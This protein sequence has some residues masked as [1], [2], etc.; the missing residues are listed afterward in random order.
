MKSNLYDSKTFQNL[1]NAF[2][3]E[4]QASSRYKQLAEEAEDKGLSEL[5]SFINTVAKN[6]Y[7][8][9][10]RIYS[11]ISS[12]TDKP[13]DGFMV[14]SNYPFKEK[15]GDFLEAFKAAAFDE[16][17]EATEI[18]PSF[19]RVARDEGF[20]D[21]AL[22]FDNLIQVETCHHLAFTEL[23]NM[24]KSDTLYSRDPAI[25]WKCSLCGYETTSKT[26]PKK[27]P[28]CGATQGKFMI[29]MPE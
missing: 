11:F 17:Q 18:Y 19:A 14:E 2:A 28:I 26:A 16:N 3:G 5:A 7:Y 29:E 21:I 15:P 25:K 9:S 23:Y 6:E 24:L 1:V 13:I 8:H 4:C 12:A 20:N 27:C 22:F 10:K